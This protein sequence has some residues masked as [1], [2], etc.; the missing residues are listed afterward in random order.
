LNGLLTV[1]RTPVKFSTLTIITRTRLNKT[2][3][4][5]IQRYASSLEHNYKMLSTA[6]QLSTEPDFMLSNVCN[7]SWVFRVVCTNVD[8]IWCRI[9]ES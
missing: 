1:S 3:K 2:K 6:L 5:Y 9:N 8:Q 4:K 7:S